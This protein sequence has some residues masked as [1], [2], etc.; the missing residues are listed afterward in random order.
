MDHDDDL[1]WA[2]GQCEAI[3]ARLRAQL[4]PDRWALPVGTLQYPAARWYAAQL[5]TWP[6]PHT[7]IDLNLDVAPY[8]DIDRGQPVFAIANGT[9]HQVGSSA[10]WVGV[11]VIQVQHQGAPLW[12]RYAHL[13]RASISLHPGDTV[14]AGQQLGVIGNY[15]P[16][17]DHLHLD[18]ASEA[19]TWSWYRTASVDWIDPVPI[20]K[21]HLDPAQVEAMLRRGNG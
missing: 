18:I 11:I 10:G 13:D 2:I 20:L 5:H 16:E 4:E 15:L 19:F 9:V 12:V 1:R 14:S 21:A 6:G 8:G 7:G 3:A 17:G